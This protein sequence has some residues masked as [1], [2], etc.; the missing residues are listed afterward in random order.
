MSRSNRQQHADNPVDIYL[1]WLGGEGKLRY[2]NK[3]TKE[4][5]TLNPELKF[6]VLD[7]KYTVTGYNQKTNQGVYAN[8]VSSLKKEPLVVREGNNEIAK[9][10]YSEI[11]E[12]LPAHVKFTQNVYACNADGSKVL[13]FKLSGSGN[14]GWI[15]FTNSSKDTPYEGNPKPD[16]YGGMVGIKLTGKSDLKKN[17]T[18]KYYEPMFDVFEI[19]E[20]ADKKAEMLDEK[21][22]AY[23][24]S[25]REQYEQDKSDFSKENELYEE[26]SNSSPA[27]EESDF[28]EP[29]DD[30]PF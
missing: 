12:G 26:A 2:Y 4:T 10:Y 1:S 22:Q 25:R 13:R 19:T 30:L 23:F 14:S 16:I 15:S 18:V 11:K 8:E 27:L 5:E 7:I 6:I 28:D 24:E 29:E 20:E 17:G 9:G 21:L 3:N